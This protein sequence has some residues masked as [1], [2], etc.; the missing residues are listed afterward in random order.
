MKALLRAGRRQFGTVGYDAASL[1]DIVAEA[2]VTTGAVYHHFSGKKGLFLAV[3]EQLEQE[4]LT[5]AS[6]VQNDDPWLQLQEASPR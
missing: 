5:K 2:R 6:A 4:L 1:E 3:A